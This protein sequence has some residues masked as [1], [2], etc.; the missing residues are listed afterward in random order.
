MEA[1][2]RQNTVYVVRLNRVYVSNVHLS[3]IDLIVTVRINRDGYPTKLILRQSILEF[4]QANEDNW[5]IPS[6]LQYRSVVASS[7]A[8][9]RRLLQKNR[10]ALLDLRFLSVR[11]EKMNELMEA[12]ILFLSVRHVKTIGLMDAKVSTLE[13]KLTAA[14]ATASTLVHENGQLERAFDTI[15]SACEEQERKCMELQTLM[16]NMSNLGPVRNLTKACRKVSKAVPSMCTI[17][18]RPIVDD[19]YRTLDKCKHSFHS[20][21]FL[22]H[23]H[24]SNTCPNCRSSFSVDV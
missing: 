15:Q 1:R 13:E 9:E 19:T 3:P 6:F 24:T 12:K 10:K 17:C 21:C 16:P 11:H 5:K 23:M 20:I 8:R 4:I 2:R 18:Q 7:R 22:R 14:R